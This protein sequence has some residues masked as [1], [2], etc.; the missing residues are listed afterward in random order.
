[1]DMKKSL[2]KIYLLMFAVSGISIKAGE[3]DYPPEPKTITI[4]T[5]NFGQLKLKAKEAISHEFHP[6]NVFSRRGL[7]VIHEAVLNRDIDFIRYLCVQGADVEQMIP[8]CNKDLLYFSKDAK[9]A[10]ALKEC[11]LISTSD[12]LIFH[13]MQPTKSPDLIKFYVAH[14][15]MDVD[16]LV[17]Y[18]GLAEG[19]TVVEDSMSPLWSLV[20]YIESYKDNEKALFL[21]KAKKLIE[22]GASNDR[23]TTTMSLTEYVDEVQDE[24]EDKNPND[25]RIE[26]LEEF[27]DIVGINEPDNAADS[28]E[29]SD[30]KE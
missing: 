28:K 7:T 12:D 17:P 6:D 26:W 4:P 11:G 8:A 5:N 13:A 23:A 27:A 19:E 2:L 22:L 21:D 3:F 10:L 18:K 29:N 1:M 30:Q 25:P 20:S 14:F 9:T 24:L 15:N 16:K